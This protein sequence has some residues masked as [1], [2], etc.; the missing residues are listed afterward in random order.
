LNRLNLFRARRL[1][2][3][4]SVVAPIGIST[5]FQRLTE[6]GDGFVALALFLIDSPAVD[7]RPGIVRLQVDGP[8][9]VGDG[10]IIVVLVGIGE[11]LVEAT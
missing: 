1:Q 7:V 6:I 3:L 5:K 10:L 2:L 11:L 9:P 8:I 4:F